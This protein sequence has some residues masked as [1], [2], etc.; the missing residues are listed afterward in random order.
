M[1]IDRAIQFLRNLLILGRVSNLPTVWTN[2]IAGWLI[3]G[4]IFGWEI[5]SLLGGVSLIYI[6]GMTLND[7]FDARWDRKNAPQRP[8]PSGS[9]SLRST[10]AIGIL[11]MV[12]G[13]L[14]L[15]AA[16]D[17]DWRYLSGLVTAVLLYNWIHKKWSG[18]VL[19]MGACRAL[20]YLLAWDAARADMRLDPTSPL[21]FL[22]SGGV[23]LYISG[24]TLAA[25]G[26][27]KAAEGKPP[28]SLS[29]FL[30]LLPT[31]FPVMTL[32]CENTLDLSRPLL[33]GGIIAASAWIVLFRSVLRNRSIP[34]GIS[35]AIAGIALYDATVALLLDWTAG[36][37]CLLC[38][39]ITLV[40][41][42]YIPA[43]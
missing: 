32:Y 28:S 24:L 20:V 31:S 36:V 9:I 43:T 42:R 22:V 8:I 11:E 14:V 1:I 25:R 23:L 40:A 30:L 18:S 12:A 2:V 34:Q 17:T 5:A 27:H 10:W 33:Y 37:A 16:G 4:G 26:E 13:C 41:Q 19:I 3:G 21:V 39:G 38:F 6:S 35:M 7:A 29:R 15:L